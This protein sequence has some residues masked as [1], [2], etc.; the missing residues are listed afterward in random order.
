MSD[1]EASVIRE[2]RRDWVTEHRE[3]YLRPKP[4]Y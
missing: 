3:K 2:A 1:A 4:T